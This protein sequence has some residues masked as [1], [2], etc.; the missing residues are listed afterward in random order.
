VFGS[1]RSSLP[2]RDRAAFGPDLAVAGFAAVIFA[3]PLH[4]T[5][6]LDDGAL[7]RHLLSALRTYPAGSLQSTFGF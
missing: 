4:A 1:A 6:Y 2:Y 5:N 7:F 3:A